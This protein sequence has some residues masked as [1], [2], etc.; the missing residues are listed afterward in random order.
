[1]SAEWENH[2]MQLLYEKY[3]HKLDMD[4]YKE[5]VKWYTFYDP[6]KDPKHKLEEKIHHNREKLDEEFMKKLKE[7]ERD[8]RMKKRKAVKSKGNLTLKIEQKKELEILKEHDQ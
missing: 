1:M 7:T 6:E 5:D 8:L 4:K 2:F 3:K